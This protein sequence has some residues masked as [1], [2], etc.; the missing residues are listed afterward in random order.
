[1]NLKTLS[2]HFFSI[3]ILVATIYLPI[4]LLHI[5]EQKL[6]KVIH[7]AKLEDDS[8]M[9]LPTTDITDKLTLLCSAEQAD[10]N[11]IM[12]N[13]KLSSANHNTTNRK[14]VPILLESLNKLYQ[15]NVVSELKFKEEPSLLKVTLSTL[16]NQLD[17]KTVSFY[18]IT[19]ACYPYRIFAV[20]DASNYLIYELDI[21]AEAEQPLFTD[22]ENLINE[23]S[24]YLKIQLKPH[25]LIKTNTTIN[26]EPYYDKNRIVNYTGN[27]FMISQ[28]QITDTNIVYNFSYTDTKNRLSIQ[29]DYE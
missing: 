12:V 5:Q 18:S 17:N 15:S 26:I 4:K 23:W 21:A 19:A 10:S 22:E 8:L 16:T 6:F 25:N 14:I 1:M 24:N 7:T 11:I 29:L 13:R 20:I 28:Q 2:I 9:Q 3:I 27:I